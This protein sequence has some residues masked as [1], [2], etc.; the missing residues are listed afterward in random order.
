MPLDINSLFA[1]IIDTPEQ[2]Q[3]KLLQQ[4]MAQGDRLASGLTGL[5]R[6]AAPLAQVAG[7]LGVQRNEN[8]R[9][10]VQPMLGIDPRTTGEKLQSILATVDTSTP[11][12][13]LQAA[14]LVQSI[15]PVRAAA[16]RQEAAR[17]KTAEEDRELN[18]REQEAR[19]RASGLQEASA[20]L[21][22]SERGQAVIDRQNYREGLPILAQ[23]VRDLGSEYEAIAVGIESN[24]LDPKEAMRDV[25]SI[26]SAKFRATPKDEFKPILDRERDDYLALANERPELNALLKKGFFGGKPDVSEARFFELAGKFR[27]MPEHKNKTPSEIIDLVQASI[28]TGTGADLLEVSVED[29]AQQQAGA[30]GFDAEAAAATAAAQLGLPATNPEE[31]QINIGIDPSFE[32]TLKNIAAT[33]GDIE[34]AKQKYINQTK[35]KITNLN[36]AIKNRQATN[37]NVDDLKQQISQLEARIANYSQ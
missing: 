6:A 30:V 23:A 37:T 25:A 10:V 34:K 5:T 9:R 26:Q 16:L 11:K 33:N 28:T 17:M 24:T 21:Q 14:N 8:L 12:G 36:A 29:M 15:D 27:S 19:L 18:R 22:I 13:M 35:A 1:D 31:A 2:R 32:A 3:M 20:A 4:G 7:Q